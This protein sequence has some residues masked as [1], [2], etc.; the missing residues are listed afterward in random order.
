MYLISEASFPIFEQF[1]WFINYEPFHPEITVII[2]ALIDK[3]HTMRK[4]SFK[5]SCFLSTINKSSINLNVILSSK[6]SKISKIMSYSG[7]LNKC[8]M[9]GTYWLRLIRGGSSCNI[10]TSLLGVETNTS[11]SRTLHLYMCHTTIK[12]PLCLH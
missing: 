8:N 2:H 11:V 10:Y 5:E 3:I 1:I 4:K 9:V 7:T 6:Y 12:G